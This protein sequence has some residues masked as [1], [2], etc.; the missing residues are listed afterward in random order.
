M[1]LLDLLDAYARSDLS[2]S[3]TSAIV[4]IET[5]AVLVYAVPYTYIFKETLIRNFKEAGASNAG[6]ATVAGRLHSY[7]YLPAALHLL[8]VV[9]SERSRASTDSVAARNYYRAAFGALLLVFAKRSHERLLEV[10]LEQLAAVDV[11]KSERLIMEFKPPS[12]AFVH[13]LARAHRLFL[14]PVFTD[15]FQTLLPVDEIYKRPV[16]FVSNHSILGFDYA[17]LLEHL[18]E[19]YGIWTRVLGDH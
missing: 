18:Y 16:L 7:A 4:A 15:S 6:D 8:I 14:D 17:M 3:L 13:R 9:R 1:G 2:S 11:A 12:V 10:D 5:A 19:R